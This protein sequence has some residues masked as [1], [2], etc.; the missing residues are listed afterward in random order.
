MSSPDPV[1]LTRALVGF[2]S[3]TPE[4]GT[5]LDYIEGLLARAGARCQRLAFG[6]AP[7]V[8]NLYARFGTEPPHLAFAG[9][10]DVVPPG[11][12]DAWRYP[13]FSGM[14]ADGRIHGRGAVDMKSGVAA[15]LAAVLQAVAERGGDLPGSLSLLL[16]G[17][18][19]GPALDGTV[20]IVET[21]LARGERPDLCVLGEPTSR[22]ALGDQIK[23]GRRGSVSGSITVR[24][25]QGHVA[26]PDRALN[27]VPALARIIAAIEAEPLDHG[28]ARFEPSRLVFIDLETNN[29]AS[30]VIPGEARAR[31]NI[32]YNTEHTPETLQAWIECRARTAA[33]E[34]QVNVALQPS[35]APAF[36]SAPSPLM[37]LVIEA[38][39]AETGRRPELSTGGG[40]SDA[41]FIKD[42]CPVVEL[43]IVGHGMHEVNE[44]A[45][46]EDIQGLA[47]IYGRLI[48]LA[49]AQSAAEPS[50]P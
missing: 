42:L 23:I 47:A 19:E 12:V 7:R 3:V 20:R 31:F 8:D 35:N 4:A 40:T 48:R 6:D 16:T 43:G 33:G 25:R 26:Y 44:S 32:R 41:R 2:E 49:F 22:D 38:V 34:A 50:S 37:D 1:A 24:G 45:S 27:P 15:A 36:L 5:A 21:L 28:N 11:P 39:R 14:V 30:N 29:V 10:L 17:D 9:H 46:I 18:E 13:P